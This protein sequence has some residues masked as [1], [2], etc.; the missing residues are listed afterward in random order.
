MI[1]DW[2]FILNLT[3]FQALDIPSR[4]FLLQFEGLPGTQEILAT[5]G[6]TISLTYRGVML[7]VGLNEK[8]PFIFD[9]LAVYADENGDVFLGILVDE[10]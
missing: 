4:K 1:F 6:K 8:N 7:S 10:T 5:K 2:F 9:G 3:E